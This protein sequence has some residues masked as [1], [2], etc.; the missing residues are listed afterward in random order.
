MDV[1]LCIK[2]DRITLKFI[3]ARL[4]VTHS[5]NRIDFALRQNGERRGALCK[6]FS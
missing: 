4:S 2:R 3:V 1:D 6:V 5:W